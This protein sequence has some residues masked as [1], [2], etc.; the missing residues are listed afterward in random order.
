MLSETHH[1]ETSR[2]FG[3]ASSCLIRGV[4]DRASEGLVSAGFLGFIKLIFGCILD[5]GHGIAGALRTTTAVAKRKVVPL[6]ASC[7]VFAANL[8]KA[9]EPPLASPPIEETGNVPRM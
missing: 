6:P 7:E 9:L 2:P 3:R 8:P 1:R 4:P 5:A